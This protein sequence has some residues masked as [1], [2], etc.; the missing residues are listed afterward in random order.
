M[1]TGNKEG[2]EVDVELVEE[3]GRVEGIPRTSSPHSEVLSE[4][5]REGKKK[6]EKVK[7][8]V[9]LATEASP[10]PSTYPREADY[11]NRIEEGGIGRCRAREGA[12]KGRRTPALRPLLIQRSCQRYNER[13]KRKEKVKG[14]RRRRER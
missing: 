14:E 9:E 5:Q 7:G 8:K 4:V 3:E 10:S 11:V 6:E 1:W 2:E 12:R 13:V